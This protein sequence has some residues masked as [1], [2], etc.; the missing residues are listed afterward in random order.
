V[1]STWT[2]LDFQRADFRFERRFRTTLP[3]AR[4]VGNHHKAFSLFS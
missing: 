2:N 4:N 3:L 1:L